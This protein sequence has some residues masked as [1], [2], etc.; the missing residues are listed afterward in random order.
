MNESIKADFSNSQ[1]DE[2]GVLSIGASSQLNPAFEGA[3]LL[4]QQAPGM[5]VPFQYGGVERE[6]VC[7][8]DTAWIGTALMTS[9]IYD[10]YGPDAAKFLQ[11]VTINKYEKM[12]MH[13]L[14]HAVMCNDKGQIL[15][16]GV[17][18]KVG[19]NR[20]R[21][22]WLNPVISYYV[23]VSEMDVHGEDMTGKEYF[24]QVAG[25]KSLEIL[26]NAFG[27]DLHDI[28]FAKHRPEMMGDKKV[29]VVRLGMSG[30]LA[31]ELHGPMEDYAEVYGKVWSSGE[32][33]GAKKQG[34]MTY[35]LFNHTE[36]GFPNINLHYPLPWFESDEGLANYLYADPMAAAFNI[37]RTLL[38]SVGDDLQSRFV[39]PYDVG[40]GFLVKFD[41]EFRGREALEKLAENPPRTVVTL[42][43]NPDDV[44]KVFA[45]Q[46]K[47]NGKCEDISRPTEQNAPENSFLGQFFYRADKVMTGGKEI[48]ISSGR[49]ISYSYHSMISL[50]FIAPE[51]AKEGTELTLLWGT[52]G[53]VQMPVRVKVSRFPYNKD[54]VRNEDKNVEDIPHLR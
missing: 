41:H 26:E 36:A 45:E 30:N 51:Y 14:R 12:N 2:S 15:T 10:I 29:E 49:I 50:G 25:E 31:Y 48:G 28:K 40:W 54:M 33:Y 19:E 24:I 13:G 38:G 7:Y 44:G 20:F 3:T 18:I 42:E 34:M 53:T 21:T 46:F 1:M 35:S 5:L 27:R 39:T 52:P 22:Y 8:R 16:D 4:F 17:V 9:P 11:S 37:S 32:K 47:S 23:S 6:S 43:W